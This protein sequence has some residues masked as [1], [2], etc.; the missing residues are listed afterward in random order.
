MPFDQLVKLWI[1]KWDKQVH[2][3]SKDITAFNKS[4]LQ[5]VILNRKYASKDAKSLSLRLAKDY[6]VQTNIAEFY[7]SS[8]DKQKIES[9]RYAIKH[10]NGDWYLKEDFKTN[11]TLLFYMSDALKAAVL[12][13]VKTKIK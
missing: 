2:N 1:N 10:L 8:L 4:D 5:Q 7:F 3:I 11:A 6:N 9:L 13:N 12:S